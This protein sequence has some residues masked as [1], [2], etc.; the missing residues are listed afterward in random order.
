MLSSEEGPWKHESNQERGGDKDLECFGL[1]S[2]E[3]TE[4][5]IIAWNWTLKVHQDQSTF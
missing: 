5:L 3:G 1:D 4:T 2:V